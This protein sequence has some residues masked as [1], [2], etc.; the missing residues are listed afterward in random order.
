MESSRVSYSTVVVSIFWFCVL[1]TLP[2]RSQ[3]TEDDRGIY[4]GTMVAVPFAQQLYHQ[5]SFTVADI[6]MTANGDLDLGYGIG[7]AAVS[8]KGISDHVALELTGTWSRQPSDLAVTLPR[9]LILGLSRSGLELPS[10][11][12]YGGEV[13]VLQSKIDLLLYPV[14]MGSGPEDG[15]KPYLGVGM[16][17]VRSDL[18]MDMQMDDPTENFISALGE[19][20]AADLVP[21]RIDEIETDYQLTLR[22]GLNFPISGMDLDLGW[23][24]YRTYVKGKDNNSH[25]AGGILKYDL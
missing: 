20:G 25:V 17:I 1:P 18:E 12:D 19:L 5:A 22:A 10:G 21:R 24:F 15:A 11:F 8:G 16:G 9:L 14:R 23:Q 7:F 6:S 3:P 4:I 2:A 13:E